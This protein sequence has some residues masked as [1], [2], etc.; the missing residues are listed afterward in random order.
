MQVRLSDQFWQPK[1]RQTALA[2]IPY[3]WKALNDEIEGAEPS[4][5]VENFRI[6]AGEQTGTF[7]GM[8]FQDSDVAKWIEAAAYSLRQYRNPQLEGVIDAVVDLMGRAQ[9]PD[10]YLNTY[11]SVA[12]PDKRWTDFAF[13]HELYCAGHLIEAAVA[14]YEST[15]KRT[16]LDIMCRYADY[17]DRIMG[18]ESERT[19]LYCGHEE[20][21]LA[22]AKLYRTTQEERYL[23]LCR[24]FIEER[25]KQPSFLKDDPGFG[26]Q[27]KDRWFELDYHQ[28]HAPVREQE[29]AEGHSVRAMYL[30]AAMADL[31]IAYGDDTLTAALRKLWDHVTSKRM[32]ITGGLGSQE[33][34][35]RFTLDYDLPN[36]TAYTETC[37][38]IGL[39]MLASRM[40]RL[41]MDSRFG[42]VMERVL[43][44]GVLSGMSLDGTRYFYVN[45]LEV[46]PAVAQYRYDM[47]HVKTERVPWFGCACCP[48]NIARLL[49]SLDTYFFTQDEAEIA[50]HLYGANESS[51]QVRGQKISLRTD[52]RY[53]WDGTIQV[54]VQVDAPTDCAI[55]FRIPAWC[56]Q[57]SIQVNGEPVA[58]DAIVTRG[59]A[60]IRRTWTD[61]DEILLHLPMVV[62][63]IESNPKVHENAGKVALQYG[64]I[65]YCLEEADN[66]ADLTDISLAEDAELVAEYREDLLGGTVVLTGEGLRSEEHSW[67]GELY[68]PVNRQKNGVRIT[69]VPYAYWGNRQPGE[70]TVWIREK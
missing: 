4:H 30:Y 6:A 69:A 19:H 53:P 1:V 23:K 51:F 41:E 58:L 2:T 34:G 62:E 12:E 39:V 42:D 63:R 26:F 49:A 22:L 24:H 25:G 56:R 50:M 28:A 16:F 3:Q 47:Q 48:P 27:F 64:P 21:E 52:T 10:G 31:A 20:I 17:I 44:N 36:D 45:P 66:G 15:G 37:A 60:R 55:A 54:R 7:Y 29:T 32:Y 33:H 68:R 70:M 8:V 65:V 43:Y 61:G 13:G 5:A 38:S 40:L 11:Y 14:Y 46:H 59:Y 18:P 67:R 9:Q 57:P 35:E